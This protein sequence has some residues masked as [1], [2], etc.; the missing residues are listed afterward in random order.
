MTTQVTLG[1]DRPEFQK[2]LKENWCNIRPGWPMLRLTQEKSS[3]N[4]LTIF[5]LFF[6]QNSIILTF[7]LKKK[8]FIDLS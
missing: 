4:Q 6:F 8:Y 1:L 3:Q 5:L 2:K 7:L